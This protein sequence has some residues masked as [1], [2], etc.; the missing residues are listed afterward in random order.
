ME[1]QWKLGGGEWEKAKV[2]KEKTVSMELNWNF[3]RGGGRGVQT[4]NN[5]PWEVLGGINVFWTH[6][7]YCTGTLYH[8]G[9]WR[10]NYCNNM[11]V[12]TFILGMK[13]GLGLTTC[14]RHV[15][16]FTAVVVLFLESEGLKP[17]KL[18]FKPSM[19]SDVAKNLATSS[20]KSKLF[21]IIPLW[22]R[23]IFVTYYLPLVINFYFLQQ[24][25]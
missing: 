2:L 21:I 10:N 25:H 20:H 6:G 18:I 24:I 4:Q 8:Y 1:G 12:G 14:M 5:C 13:G 9:V 22:S 7:M 19:L 15:L 11:H 3:W 23:D 16:E 17:Q